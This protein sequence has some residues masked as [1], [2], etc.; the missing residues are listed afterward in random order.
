MPYEEILEKI[1]KAKELAENKKKAHLAGKPIPISKLEPSFSATRAASVL[2]VFL[3]QRMM[4][5][6]FLYSVCKSSGAKLTD[7]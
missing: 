3:L 5:N 4:M 7:D 1:K 2:R 6:H